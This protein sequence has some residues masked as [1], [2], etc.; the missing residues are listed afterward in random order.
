MNKEA[1][2]R[3]HWGYDSFKP[4]QEL[5]IDSVLSNNDTIALLPTGGGKSICYQI[6]ALM[7][8]GF[9]LVISPLIALME[10]QVNELKSIG[11]K[12]MYFESK[13]N[14]ISL[15]HQLD[16]AIHGNYKVIYVSPERFSNPFFTEQIKNAT[17]SLIAVDEAHCI[18]EWGHDFRPS[19]RKIDTLRSY[20]P[21]VPILALTASA[22]LEVKRDI[23]I[24][25]KLKNPF[26]FQDSL[27]RPNISYNFF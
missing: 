27:H 17:I 18:S 22:T 19:Y 9:V 24:Q 1:L 15:L 26:H 2:L 16:N 23:E 6:P 5:I 7:K 14:S 3:I 4:L 20:L 10:D 12:S 21:D 8:E 13:S 11:I 25:L